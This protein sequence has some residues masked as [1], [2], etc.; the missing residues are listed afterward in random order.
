MVGWLAAEAD[1]ELHNAGIGGG[2]GD[3]A[4]GGGAEAAVWLGKGG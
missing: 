3:A 1:G 4:E 2:A